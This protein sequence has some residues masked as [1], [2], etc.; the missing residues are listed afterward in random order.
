MT[1]DTDT[2]GKPQP[3]PVQPV[4]TG[5]PWQ[6]VLRWLFEQGAVVVVLIGV[7][8]AYGYWMV[9][10][11]EEGYK[12]NANDLQRSAE[13]YTKSNER[14]VDLILKGAERDRVNADLDRKN[15]HR[16]LDAME[17]GDSRE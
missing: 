17:R 12:A 8:F 1:S 11:I 6:L 15:L 10:K 16:A 9:P 14:I 5:T 4:V 7:I 3:V 2:N 13:V